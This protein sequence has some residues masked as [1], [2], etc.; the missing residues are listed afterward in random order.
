VTVLMQCAGND[1][2]RTRE[3]IRLDLL[4]IPVLSEASLDYEV[5]VPGTGTGTVCLVQ[6]TAVAA[7]LF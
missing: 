6:V 5:P 1:F 4:R 7:N 2:S 3:F